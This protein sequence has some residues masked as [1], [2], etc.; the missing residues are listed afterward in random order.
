MLHRCLRMFGRRSRLLAARRAA[1]VAQS[2]ALRDRLLWSAAQAHQSLT[3]LQV[4]GLAVRAA[5]RH[6]LA[7]IVGGALLGVLGPRRVVRTLMAGIAL[8]QLLQRAR[9]T[10]RW[11]RWLRG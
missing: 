1:L 4:G 3:V 8:W 7:L 6:P 11:M 5:A 10:L 2:D 9:G